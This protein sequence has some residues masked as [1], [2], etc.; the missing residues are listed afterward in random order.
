MGKILNIGFLA[1]DVD[2]FFTREA[3]RGGELGAMAIDANLFVFPGMYLDDRK[4]SEDHSTYEYQF[5]TLFDFAKDKKLDIIYVMLGL[6]GSRVGA[7]KRAEFL[8]QYT[9]IPVVTLY[10]ETEGYPSI[11]FD[12]RVAFMAGIRHLIRDHYARSIGYV[13]GPK[14]N[15]DAMERLNAYLDVLREQGIPYNEDLIIYGNFEENVE[16]Q[17]CELVKKHPELD[18]L[19]FA[20]DQM[21]L[22]GYR[23]LAKLNMRVGQD[24]LVMGFDN[25]DFAANLNP[26]LTTVEANEAELSYEAVIHA[27]DFIAHKENTNIEIETH[28]VHRSSCGCY[29][30]DFMSVADQI[31]ISDL[32]TAK[33]AEK[34]IEKIHT[35]L[36]GSFASGCVLNALDERIGRF[37]HVLRKMYREK[38]IPEYKPDAEEIFSDFTGLSLFRYTTYELFT[39]F[40]SACKSLMYKDADTEMQ[41]ETA[42]FFDELF[43]TLAMSGWKLYITQKETMNRSFKIINDLTVNMFGKNSKGELPFESALDS[44]STIGVDSAC[45]YLYDTPVIHTRNDH[46]DKPDNI[47]FVAY[48]KDGRSRRVDKDHSQV[49]VSTI[50]SNPVM[51]D[52]TRSTVLLLPLFSGEELFGIMECEAHSEYFQNILPVSRQISVAV[53]TMFL[54]HQ[55]EHIQ[56]ELRKNLDKISQNNELLSRISKTDPLTGLFNRRGFMDAVKELTGSPVSAGKNAV[57]VYG[58]LD[59]L[60]K[61]NDMYGHDEGDFAIKEAAVMLR[62]AFRATDVIS[63]FGGD[64]FVVFAIMNKTDFEPVLKQ[65]LATITKIHNDDIGKPYKVS[66]STGVAECTFDENFNMDAMMNLADRKLYIEKR[67]RKTARQ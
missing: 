35:Y 34:S 29:S 27:K 65:R 28:L 62:E 57:L 38:N 47:K 15:V 67:E 48:Y 25:S 14:T 33:T 64:E 5:N 2:S 61:I 26:P 56:E 31:G 9:G 17:V 11:I 24:I 13:S 12:N 52:D 23:A 60:K 6:I 8:E 51:P 40:L 45:L 30:F 32:Y 42:D 1:D 7:E 58:D 43:R 20:N 55:Q 19:V 54:L 59:G 16:D 22:G 49:P 44:I 10:T 41:L 21:A 46:F 50:F 18:A 37:V 39:N 4:F 36:F 66:L 3:I 63:R 53:K